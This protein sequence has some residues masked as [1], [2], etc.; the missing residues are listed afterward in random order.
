[1]KASL[2]PL[3]LLGFAACS[4]T[5]GSGGEKVVTDAN[6]HFEPAAGSQ[7]LRIINFNGSIQ[8]AT[9]DGATNLDGAAEIWARGKTLEHAQ[10]R[11]SQM[12][13]Q[14]TQA[15][16]TV[17][18][19]LSEPIGGSNNAG[20]KITRLVVPKGWSLEVETSNGSVQIPAGFSDVKVDTSNG[21]V[22]VA[23][24]QTVV[25]ETSNGNVEY[26]G[27]SPNFHIETSNGKV[28]VQLKGDW[29]GTGQVDTSN[30]RIA[31]RCTGLIDARL[32]TSTSNGSTFVYGP[33]LNA[34]LGTGSLHLDTSNGN[35]SVTHSFREQ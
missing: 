27:A 16:T 17:V 2:A 29:S 8:L 21:S 11:L 1:M 5:F 4:L 35:I 15:G 32:S 22:K 12:S 20:S 34:D 10:S 18:M 30:G 7:V 13:W 28:T 19:R 6:L 24:G 3:L 26:L 31:V 33:E 23:G 14:F 25:V 9:E